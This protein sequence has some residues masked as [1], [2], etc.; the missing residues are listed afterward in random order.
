VPFKLGNSALNVFTCNGHSGFLN[1]RSERAV[2]E[3]A[4]RPVSVQ[5]LR[6]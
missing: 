5:W 3:M 2:N 6:T 1:P 4:L